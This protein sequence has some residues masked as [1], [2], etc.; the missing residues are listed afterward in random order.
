MDFGQ[1]STLSKMWA[2]VTQMY[3][4]KKPESIDC[5]LSTR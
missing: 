4:R 5:F 3:F 1:G 2:Q